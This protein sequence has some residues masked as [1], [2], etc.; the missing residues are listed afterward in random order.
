MSCSNVCRLCKRLI[1]SSAVTFDAGTNTLIVDIPAAT[2]YNHEKYCIVIA[3]AIPAE[4]TLNAVVSVS[5]GG[6]TT[7][8]YPL[9]KCNCQQATACNIRTRTRYSTVVATNTVGGVFRLL[10]NIGCCG[11][12][13][14]DSL[15]VVAATT[16]ATPAV[17]QVLSARTAATTKTKTKEGTVN[18]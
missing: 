1:I 18:E 11:A 9:V 13:V 4:T 5:I 8:L 14:L 7:T 6:D 2:Y 10:G 16:T 3:Q 15:P 17:A 12:E